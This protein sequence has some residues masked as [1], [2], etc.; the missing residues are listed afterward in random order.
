MEGVGGGE[1][2]AAELWRRGDYGALS[3]VFPLPS[4]RAPRAEQEAG[5]EPGRSS[6]TCSH[7][8]DSSATMMLPKYDYHDW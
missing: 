7:L 8:V 3:I 4:K 1:G 6:S 5:A 2:T